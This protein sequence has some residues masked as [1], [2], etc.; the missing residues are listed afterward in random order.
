MNYFQLIEHENDL[1]QSCKRGPIHFQTT[2]Y[3][4]LDLRCLKTVEFDNYIASAVITGLKE[5]CDVAVEGN[6]TPNWFS[7]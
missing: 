1:V 3:L 7:L 2:I 4:T 5:V 6:K